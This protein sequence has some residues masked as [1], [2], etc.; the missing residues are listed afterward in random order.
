MTEMTTTMTETTQSTAT[1]LRWVRALT[2]TPWRRWE[3][4]YAYARVKA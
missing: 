1:R 2:A 3:S 4:Y